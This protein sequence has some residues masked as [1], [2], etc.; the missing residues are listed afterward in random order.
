MHVQ[1]V[2]RKIGTI[3]PAI[4]QVISEKWEN[5]ISQYSLH[6]L[7]DTFFI[8]NSNVNYNIYIY[9]YL[10]AKN[11]ISRRLVENNFV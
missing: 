4:S 5:V 2:Q 1:K 6:V 9:F 11:L 8:C 7:I 10:A 3:S